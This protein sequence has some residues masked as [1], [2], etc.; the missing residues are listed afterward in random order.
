MKYMSVNLLRFFLSSSIDVHVDFQTS[1][2]D[3]TDVEVHIQT[4]L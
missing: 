4:V 1:S 2:T 3:Q